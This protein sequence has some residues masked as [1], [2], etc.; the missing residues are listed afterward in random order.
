MGIQSAAK[1]MDLD[2][3]PIGMEHYDFVIP[4]EY[5]DQDHVKAFIEILKSDP[6]REK[7]GELGGYTCEDIGNIINTNALQK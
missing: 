7:L 4:T 5:L 1:A 6:F 2:F 3:V